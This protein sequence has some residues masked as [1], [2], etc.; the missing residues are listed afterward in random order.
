[1]VAVD[2]VRLP[3]VYPVMTDD[4]LR[5]LDRAEQAMAGAERV[6][7]IGRQG[8]FTPDN[9]HHVIEMGFAAADSVRADGSFDH[10]G[11]QRRRAGFR[12]FVVED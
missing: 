11:W 12:E 2:T 3:S 4:A 6:T 7:V 8:L 9:T 5:R 1:M 10:A